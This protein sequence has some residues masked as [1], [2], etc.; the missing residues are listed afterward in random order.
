MRIIFYGTPDFAVPSLQILIENK[1]NVVAVVTAADSPAG[2]GLQMKFSPVKE[3]AISQ[4]IKVL[5][6]HKLKDPVFLEEIKSLMP[7]LQI[8][9]AF[10]MMP[11]VLWSMPPLGSFNLHGSLLPQYRG[12]APINWAI[13][14]GEKETGVTTFFLQQE[15]D[16]GNII[17]QEKIPIDER[18][19]ATTLHNKMMHTGAALVLKTAWAIN[20]GE[21]DATPQSKVDTNELKAAPKIFK[22]TCAINFNNEVDKVNNFVRGLSRYPAAYT[23]IVS[24][25]NERL[26]LKIYS[27]QKEYGEMNVAAGNMQTDGKTFLKFACNNGWLHALE[28][29]LQGKKAMTVQEFLRGFKFQNTNA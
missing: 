8:V 22:E 27:A 7:D 6:P 29:Q 10:R 15:I 14:N 13:I 18:D 25:D 2:R 19:N 21:V 28:L 3:Y 4:N 1:F 20:N 24:K 5:Q 23:Y 26:Q 11:Q 16:T 12:A 9:V 17:F